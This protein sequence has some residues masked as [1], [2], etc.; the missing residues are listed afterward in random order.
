VVTG[1]LASLRSDTLATATLVFVVTVLWPLGRGRWMAF[2]GFRHFWTYPPLWP[3][4]AT[5]LLLMAMY[6]GGTASWEPVL[7]HLESLWWLVAQIPQ[8]M[9]L[10]VG[11][12]AIA[13]VVFTEDSAPRAQ[14]PGHSDD[15]LAALVGWLRDDREIESPQDDRFG[16]DVVAR[17][18]VERLT[19]SDGENPTMAVVGPLGSG[20]STIRRLVEHHLKSHRSIQTLNVSLW[21]FD[22]AEAAVAGI[23]RSVV[24]ALGQHVGTLPLMGLSERYVSAIERVG[25]R[26]GV[27]AR[28]LGRESQPG[29]TLQRLALIATAAGIKLVLWIEDMERFTGADRL[30]PDE[31]ALREAERLGPILSLLVLLDR[32]DSISVVVGDTSLRSRLD[33]G[34]IARFV[35]SPP[36]LEPVQIWRQIA[37]LRSACLAEPYIDPAGDQY[38]ETLSPPA[39]ESKFNIWAW[40][41]KGTEPRVQEAVAILTNTPRVF[42]SAL[43]LTWETWERIGGEIDIDSVLVASVLRVSRPDIFALVDEHVDLF[44]LGFRD[45]FAGSDSN[46]RSHPVMMQLDALLARENTERERNAVKALIGFVF[47]AAMRTWNRDDEFISCPQGLSVLRHADYWRR[48]LSLPE[49]GQGF[50]DQGALRSIAAWKAR[51]ESDLLARLIEPR[52]ASQIG[53]FVGQFSPSE[54]CRLLADIAG[55]LR[56]ESASGWDM[57]EHA[58]GI[59]SV[60]QMMRRR[61]PA[62]EQLAQAVAGLMMDLVAHHLPLANDIYYFFAHDEG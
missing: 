31:A 16:H 56:D 40:S 50:S 43:R 24:A 52:R 28:F 38:R 27:L 42:K 20:K 55:A 22:S 26:W 36:R 44:R 15:G 54:L 49:V 34:K 57:G 3:A 35:E 62:S 9:W 2:L 53:T 23:L 13:L 14:A 1:Y 10:A 41:I 4:I 19:K 58:P 12:G 29:S 7:E 45:A 37:I 11:A 25:G 51:K 47:P 33:V 21:P 59:T 8:W 48:Y 18:I 5:A 17:R 61:H 32:C 46:G 39:D 30:P 60:W 6:T